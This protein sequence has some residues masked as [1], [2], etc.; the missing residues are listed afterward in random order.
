M[1]SHWVQRLAHIL[2]CASKEPV[3]PQQLVQVKIGMALSRDLEIP[4]YFWMYR[5]FTI[6]SGDSHRI[7]T[8]PI[9]R[10]PRVRIKNMSQSLI[11]PPELGATACQSW[12]STMEILSFL[13]IFHWFWAGK[14]LQTHE[15]SSKNHEKSCFFNFTQNIRN[16]SK[17]LSK[18]IF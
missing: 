2:A 7:R 13:S 5:C 1:S 4:K 8:P 16:D 3:H 11:T 18:H 9:E 15:N 14:C 17:L 10:S 6:A 12:G